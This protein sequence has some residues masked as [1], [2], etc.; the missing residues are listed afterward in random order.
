MN[1]AASPA[2]LSAAELAKMDIA[3]FSRRDLAF[4]CS[5]RSKG[6]A[7]ILGDDSR[8]WVV[9]MKNAARLERAGY[10]WAGR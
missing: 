7:V 10:E 1:N 6:T 5:D 9:S 8:F 2:P 4:S 3:R